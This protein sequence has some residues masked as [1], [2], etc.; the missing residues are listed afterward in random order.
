MGRLF[1]FLK[2]RAE[3]NMS[4]QADLELYVQQVM[5]KGR[6]EDVRKL[7]KSPG[8][9]KTGKIFLWYRKVCNTFLTTETS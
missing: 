6:I 4:N 5:T 9:R 1:W 2:P 3:L 7:L 8:D